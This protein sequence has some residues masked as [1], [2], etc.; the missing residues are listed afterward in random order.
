[1]A[2]TIVNQVVEK[3]GLP[4]EAVQ[5]TFDALRAII[6]EQCA[7]GE[8]TSIRGICTANPISYRQLTMNGITTG[9][10]VKLKASKTLTAAVE[11]ASLEPENLV[12][13][14]ENAQSIGQAMKE[15]GIAVMEIPGLG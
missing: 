15:A 9:F 2:Y 6:I 10:T 4:E 3:T 11:K 1:M 14:Q 12:K 5:K 8:S 13:A 7:I